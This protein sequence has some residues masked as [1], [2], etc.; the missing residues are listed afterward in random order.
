MVN[1][2]TPT[3]M[4]RNTKATVPSNVKARTKQHTD[5]TPKPEI[6]NNT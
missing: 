3:P 1:P 6:V 4:V 5:S 2:L